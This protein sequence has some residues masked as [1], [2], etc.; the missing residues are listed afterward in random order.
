MVENRRTRSR[1]VVGR[2]SQLHVRQLLGK[3]RAQSFRQLCDAYRRARF[4]LHLKHR[5]F[6]A[7]VPEVDQVDRVT[8]RVHAD[9]PKRDRDVVRADFLLDQ[10]ECLQR[11]FLGAFESGARQRAQPQLELAGIRLRENFRGQHVS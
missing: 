8:R 9:E 10:V 2:K 5:F 7:A 6:G 3:F 1:R 4:Q 11:D